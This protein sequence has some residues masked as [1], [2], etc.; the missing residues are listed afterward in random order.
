MYKNI[1]L[2]VDGSEHSIRATQEAI[3]IASLSNECTIKIV[4]VADFSKAKN[5]VLHA[6][7]KEELELSRRKRLLPIEEK[8]KSNGVSYEI[9]ILHG[10]PGPT[11][12][13]YANKG[14]FDLVVLGSR[15]LNTLQEMV[16]GSVSHKVAKRVQ[17]PV[18][19]V[20]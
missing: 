13:D 14:N 1:L 7:G 11:I 8:L 4:F 16:L 15:G 10:E 20:K 18:L 2:A 3:K 6:Q 17:C 19:L 5:E 12:V 9:K